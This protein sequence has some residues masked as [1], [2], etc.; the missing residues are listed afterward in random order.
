MAAGDRRGGHLP[1]LQA[2]NLSQ[3]KNVTAAAVTSDAFADATESVRI[4]SD[5]DLWY[6]GTNGT[7]TDAVAEGSGCTYLPAGVVEV[8]RIPRG[9][10]YQFSFIRAGGADG[11]VNISEES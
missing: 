10:D 2:Q 7:V 6:R 3:T 9:T 1:T 4:V 8:K 5:V 11:F